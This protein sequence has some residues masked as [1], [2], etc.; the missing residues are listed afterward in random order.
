[1]WHSLGPLGLVVDGIISRVATR[2][3]LFG[4]T[5]VCEDVVQVIDRFEI[6]GLAEL[7]GV[8]HHRIFKEI[9]QIG[10][11]RKATHHSG[12]LAR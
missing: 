1:M 10:R 5:V 4:A 12:Q 11:G 3:E 2:D 6:E 7:A 8:E 9:E